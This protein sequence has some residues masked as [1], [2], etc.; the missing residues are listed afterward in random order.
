VN[1]KEIGWYS[2]EGDAADNM[3][4]YWRQFGTN[5]GLAVRFI[6]T[7]YFKYEIN[8]D[9]MIQ[10]NTKSG[11]RRV[12]R[13][14]AP[15][16]EASAEAPTE[17]PEP[18]KPVAP[19]PESD[20]DDDEE[21]ADDM[22]DGDEDEEEAAEEEAGVEDEEE[23]PVVTPAATADAAPFSPKARAPPPAVDA[24]PADDVMT[25]ETLP[26]RGASPKRK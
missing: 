11:T 26:L 15:G 16:E 14:V 18:V 5:D 12:I 20:D 1:G 4:K 21:M 8:Y 24:Q 22:D 13:R 25:A 9:T 7:D 17:I 19:A 3:E 6:S 23:A 10:T 2:Y